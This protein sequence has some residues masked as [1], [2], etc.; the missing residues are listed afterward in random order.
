M[1]PKMIVVAGPPG[2]G[3]SSLYPLS[4]FG[5]PY[6]NADDRAAELNG[7]L[8]AGISREIRQAVN[9]EFEAFVLGSIERRVS[10]AFETTLR[11]EVTFDQAQ[12]AKRAGFVV[13][14]RYLALRDFGMH[15]D[16]V[17]ARA[18]AGG[19]SASGTTLRRIYDASLMN[20]RRAVQELDFVWVY[21]NT[22]IDASHPLVLEARN[23][24]IRFLKENPPRWLR[25]ALYVS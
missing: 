7:G 1:T 13:E 24:E 5:V 8:Y 2:S 3:K 20:L 9:R 22:D 18:D 17:K 23:G 19:H 6:F 21:D 16:R 4:T 10:F 14:M 12:L 11:S 25:E 15:L